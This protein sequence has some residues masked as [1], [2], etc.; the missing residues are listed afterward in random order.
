[1][2]LPINW[3]SARLNNI[4]KQ[5]FFSLQKGQCIL[6]G[7]LFLSSV[8]PSSFQ[9]A[10]QFELGGGAV[11]LMPRETF[12]KGWG[13]GAN[14]G[15]NFSPGYEIHLSVGNVQVRAKETNSLKVV[16][17]VV[18]GVEI[19]FRRRGQAHGFTS[20]GLGS[21]SGEDN[22]LFVFGAGIKIPIQPKWLM[23]IELRDYHPEIGIPFVS[24]PK[25]QAAIQGSGGS[26]YLELRLGLSLILKGNR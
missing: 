7:L 20:I 17:S 24:F 21:V 5:V 8:L 1:M 12:N 3:K 11:L 26:R 15:W 4:Q 18:A 9:T 16:Q 22:T 14:V 25:S 2:I 10:T 6:W 19:S 13:Y 23:R